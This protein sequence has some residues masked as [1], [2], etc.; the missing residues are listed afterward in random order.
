MAS[1]ITLTTTLEQSDE[2]ARGDGGTTVATGGGGTQDLG[3]G[4][5]IREDGA[6]SS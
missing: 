3:L 2:A 4:R 5:D 6:T 1:E